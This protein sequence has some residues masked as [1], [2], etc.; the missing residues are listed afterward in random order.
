MDTPSEHLPGLFLHIIS[1]LTDH[2]DE[3]SPVEVAR[4]LQLCAK[5]LSRVQPSMLANNPVGGNKAAGE[6]NQHPTTGEIESNDNSIQLIQTKSSTSSL[7][8]P[9]TSKQKASGNKLTGKN[10]KSKFKLKQ[11]GNKN[12]TRTDSPV[13]VSISRAESEERLAADDKLSEDAVSPDLAGSCEQLHISVSSSGRLTPSSCNGSLL[14][15]ADG[16]ELLRSVSDAD[17]SGY[18]LS[19]VSENSRIPLKQQSIL[20]QCLKQYKKFYVKFVSGKR[21]LSN[22]IEQL[23]QKLSIVLPPETDAE[24]CAKLE[25]ILTTCLYCNDDSSKENVNVYKQV[26]ISFEGLE[27]IVKSNYCSVDCN[28]WETPMKVASSLLVELSTFPTYCL[29]ESAAAEESKGEKNYSIKLPVGK[30][31]SVNLT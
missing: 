7:E 26:A 25:D 2:C 16:G 31:W 11:S 8:K 28:K 23:F 14:H 21:I 4:S 1:K 6:L 27:F 10:K 5:I 22:T 29:P 9:K 17:I 15:L 19:D 30:F 18:S 12:S 24:R 13:F 3:L 20:E